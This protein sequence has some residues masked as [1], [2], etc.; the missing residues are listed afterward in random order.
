MIQRLFFLIFLFVPVLPVRAQ[1]ALPSGSHP[2]AL[3]FEHFPGKMYAFIWRNW[4]LVAPE[5]MA[6]VLGCSRSQLLQQA[7][8]M[9]LPAA[10]PVPASFKKQLYITIIRRN[11]HLLPYDQL[12]L[13]LG[14]NEQELSFALKEDDF[15][16]IK[17]GNLKPDCTPVVFKVP[18]PP[19]LQKLAAIKKIAHPYFIKDAAPP[20]SFLNNFSVPPASPAIQPPQP[21]AL[22]FIYSYF[23][24]FGDPLTDTLQ[25]P[26]P[27]GLLAR[28]AQKGITGV[29]M[30]VV[31]HQLAPGGADFPEWNEG[32]ATRIA[33]LRKI[34]ERAAKYGISVYLY[35]N[36][37]RAMPE[38]FFKN[39]PDMMGA[40][41]DGYRSLCIY[42]PKVAAWLKNALQYVF[43]QVPNLGGVFTI[44]ASENYTHCASHNNQ[45]TCS[46][47]S[48]MSYAGI[49]G[50]VNTLIADGVH[51]GNKDAKVI[52]WDWGWHHH[53]LAKDVIDSLP[54][55]VW[56]MSVSEWQQPV[57]RGGIAS[58]IGEYSISA[59]GPGSRAQQHWAE[60]QKTGLK[61]VA[62]V[63]FNNSWELSAVPWIPVADLI[64][65]HAQNL[66]Q[67]GVNGYMLSWSLGGYPSPNLEIAK[68]FTQ[69]PGADTETVLHALARQRYGNAA[70]LIRKAWTAFSKAFE[71]F[72]FSTATL[73]T[74]P[75]QYGPANLLFASPT[76]YKASMVGF[77]YDDLTSWRS[78][79]P[80]EVF[81]EQWRTLCTG[82]EQGLRYLDTAVGLHNKKYDSAVQEE[83]RIARAA[84][85]HFASVSHQ[86]AFIM[87]RGRLQNNPVPGTAIALRRQQLELLDAEIRV[88]A[89]QLRLIAQDSRIGFEASNQYYYVAQDLVE[90][91]LNCRHL[92]QL[93]QH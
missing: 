64:A 48:K 73:Y 32:Y 92:K 85:N 33:N 37:P 45:Q 58:T 3:T 81:L 63:Q 41:Q 89:S 28:L 54:P 5:T 35:I 14:M 9:G 29:W 7:D 55:S 87:N 44:T 76:G 70:P 57:N 59:V 49:I 23:G 8:L 18:D 12:L 65:R 66:A 17:L 61:T 84:Y 31:L 71:A 80:P 51:A 68:A 42:H 72:P 62:K 34:A 75:Q 22:R 77:P 53:G 83:Q 88:A 50:K 86:V 27:D 60:A 11:W 25:N 2:T 1:E 6:K 82:W 16:F 91:I 40:R 79:Y 46:R 56:L 43:S 47:C 20:F 10:R 15:L 39:R 13:L 4:N 24:V 93:L 30:H 74:A 38:A 26:Y 21:D 52:V 69:D 67:T 36:E 90:K 78:I 19:T